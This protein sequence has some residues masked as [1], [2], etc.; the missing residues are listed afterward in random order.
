MSLIT[1]EAH[2]MPNSAGIYDTVPTTEALFRSP[3]MVTIFDLSGISGDHTA[4]NPLL[5]PIRWIFFRIILAK[6]QLTVSEISETVIN[7]G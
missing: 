4:V 6:G 1:A 2:T 5:I 3:V 7:Q